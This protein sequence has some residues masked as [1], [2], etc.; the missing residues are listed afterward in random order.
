M[1][2]KRNTKEELSYCMTASLSIVKYIVEDLQI[3]IKKLGLKYFLMRVFACMETIRMWKEH[4]ISPHTHALEIQQK[5]E[6]MVIAIL[7]IFS[8]ENIQHSLVEHL[9]IFSLEICNRFLLNQ[10]FRKIRFS[11]SLLFLFIVLMGNFS[12]T[13]LGYVIISF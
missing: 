11:C 12:V 1:F 3:P 8:D 9:V 2:F 13:F 5:K 10:L 6:K 7:A 4:L